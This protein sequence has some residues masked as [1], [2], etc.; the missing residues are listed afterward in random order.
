MTKEELIHA[1]NAVVW[2]NG[3]AED[4]LKWKKIQPSE[5]TGY[6][7]P[8]YYKKYDGQLKEWLEMFWMISVMLFGDYGTSPRS[9]WIEKKE[10]FYK[11]IDDI[12]EIYRNSDEYLF[13]R[14]LEEAR[15]E[16][17]DKICQ[18]KDI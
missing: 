8:D 9:G 6:I 17:E 7:L 15:E 5:T 18:K 14:Y 4:I 3:I 1:L 2:Y 11:F 13:H 16:K 10:E 12:T